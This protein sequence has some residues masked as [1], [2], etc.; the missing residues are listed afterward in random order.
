MSQRLHYAQTYQP[1]WEGGYFGGQS[2]D[3]ASLVYGEFENNY[4]MNDQ[5]TACELDRTDINEYIKKL[6][7]NP[8]EPNKYFEGQTDQPT[9]KQVAEVFSLILQS[10]DDTIHMEWF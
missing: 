8:D 4:W 5:E 6:L 9:N 2:D 1:K 10:D 7:K 3:F